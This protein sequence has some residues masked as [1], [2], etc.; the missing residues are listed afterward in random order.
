MQRQDITTVM[1]SHDL[2]FCGEYADLVGMFFDGGI[3][4]DNPPKRFFGSNSFYTTVGN[5]M[6][7]SLWPQAVT[8]SDI[9]ERIQEDFR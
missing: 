2:E 4:T 5:R 6:S 1:V 8:V 7:R 3:I 9:V